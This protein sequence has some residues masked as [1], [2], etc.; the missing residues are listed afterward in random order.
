[1]ADE[2]DRAAVIEQ[3]DRENAIAAAR[4]SKKLEATGFCLWCE[5]PLEEGRRFCDKG[6]AED[7]EFRGQKR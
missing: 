5:E 6:C 2:A 1:M 3:R 4:A 7:F